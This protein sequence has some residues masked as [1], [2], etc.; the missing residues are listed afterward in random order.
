MLATIWLLF[1]DRSF[2]FAPS[3]E[4]IWI[5]FLYFFLILANCQARNLRSNGK[6]KKNTKKICNKLEANN[7]MS[8]RIRL[9]SPPRSLLGFCQSVSQS[10]T[11]WVSLSLRHSLRAV[12]EI[13]FSHGSNSRAHYSNANQSS[14]LSL[15][16]HCW[17]MLFFKWFLTSF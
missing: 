8:V 2:S 1:A 3:P 9:A 12:S 4:D 10:F 7:Q 6:Y 5:Y 13:G 11:Q 15:E 17:K 16:L 14:L